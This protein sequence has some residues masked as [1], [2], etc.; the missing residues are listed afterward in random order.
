M[1]S[2][3]VKKQRGVVLVV[4]MIILLVMSVIGIS[5]LTSSTMQER[6][7]GNNR[8]LALA[9]AAAEAALK[10]AEGF[11]V[12]NITTGADLTRF[13]NAAPADIGLYSSYVL[14]SEGVGLK[15]LSTSISDIQD[16]SLWTV[17]NSVA[18]GNLSANVKTRDPR[19]VIEYIGRETQGKAKPW[20]VGDTSDNKDPHIFMI[21][22]IGWGR[23]QNIYT[24][25][26]ST[27]RTGSGADFTY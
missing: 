23:D 27:F 14:N 20:I 1:N 13:D 15:L 19:F 2:T 5:S 16:D 8:Q 6:M 18:A 10:S 11:L 9:K 24:V 22:A 17:G 25:L 4:A 12:A 21:T 26:Q 7:A 3:T